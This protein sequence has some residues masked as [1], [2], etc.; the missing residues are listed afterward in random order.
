MNAPKA[1]CRLEDI[2]DG[3]GRAFAI[4]REDGR[5]LFVVRAGD[6]AYGYV[7]SCPHTGGPLDLVP[8]RFMTADKRYVIC[9]THGA[10]FRIE[11]GTCVAGPCAGKTLEAVRVRRRHGDL[12]LD[13]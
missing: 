5:E 7:N 6:R 3:E 11:D 8:D 9:A 2:P 12:L 10:T 4:G 13:D 1:L